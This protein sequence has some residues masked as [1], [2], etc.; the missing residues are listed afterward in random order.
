MSSQR[1]NFCIVPWVNVS[2]DVNG[3][4]RPCCKFV[5]PTEQGAVNLGNLN[6]SSL[7]TIWNSQEMQALRQDFLNDTRNPGCRTCWKEEDSGVPSY[8]MEFAQHRLEGLEEKDFQTPLAKP[9]IA[10]DLKLSQKCNLKC[11]ICGPIASSTFLEEEL[12]RGSLTMDSQEKKYLSSY[13]ILGSQKEKDWFVS[14]IPQVQHIEIFG[15]EPLLSPENRELEDLILESGRAEK[16]SLLYNTNTTLFDSALVQ[17]WKKFKR[18][19][20]CLSVDDI[21]E[22]LHYERYPAS[23]EKIEGNIRKYSEQKGANTQLILFC[24]V[25]FFNVYFLPEYIEWRNRNFP[26]VALDFNLVHDLN[27]FSIRNLRD[28]VKSVVREKLEANQHLLQNDLELAKYRNVIQYMN[29]DPQ[30][31]VPEIEKQL[32]SEVRLRDQIRKQSWEEVFSDF[33]RLYR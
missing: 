12:K 13:K 5:Q 28:D 33:S 31:P 4:V 9:P 24:S 14:L 11:R 6:K 23:F 29:M 20:V 21:H 18:V 7:E 22:R 26:S 16:I 1:K 8:R 2:I 19:Q 15:G 3:S 10:F 27:F 32:F 30:G 25:S 17:K